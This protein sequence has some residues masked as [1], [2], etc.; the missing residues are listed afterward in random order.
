[1]N[2]GSKTGGFQ[3]TD[4]EL[5]RFTHT[6]SGSLQFG[7]S[8]PP[9][10]GSTSSTGSMFIAGIGSTNFYSIAFYALAPNK[11]VAFE[12]VTSTFQK[13]FRAEA[14]GGVIMSSSKLPYVP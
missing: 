4:A 2:F 1:M 10:S 3:V 9:P 6:A 11:V 12:D 8:S 13:G 7:S 14:A 5:A